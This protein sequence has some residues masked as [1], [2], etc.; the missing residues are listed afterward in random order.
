MP[1]PISAVIALGAELLK[2]IPFARKPERQ[3][4]VDAVAKVLVDTAKQVSPG[5]AN[6]QAAFER[7]QSDPAVKAAFVA[8][9]AERWSDVQPYLE[10][11]ARERKEARAFAVSLTDGEGWRALGAGLLIGLL[12]IT[13]VVG[14]G[15]MFWELM[16]SPQLDPGQKGLILGALLTAFTTTVGFWFGSSASSRSKDR[17]IEDQAKR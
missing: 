16:D 3:E 13:I 10:F 1:L 11:E 17:T 9:V 8:K 5:A 6:E 7:V 4:Q 14:G 12:S 2:L 15:A